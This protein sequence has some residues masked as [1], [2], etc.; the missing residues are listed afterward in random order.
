MYNT[1]THVHISMCAKVHTQIKCH[2]FFFLFKVSGGNVCRS[3]TFNNVQQISSYMRTGILK[4]KPQNLR[5]VM[6]SGR[7]ETA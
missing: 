5:W 7:Q 1:H 2:T 6:V 4:L 3:Q